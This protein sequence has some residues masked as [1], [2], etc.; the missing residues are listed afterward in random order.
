MVEHWSNRVGWLTGNTKMYSMQLKI[1]QSVD[2]PLCVGVCVTA[3]SV[4]VWRTVVC[5]PC[6]V[7][8]AWCSASEDSHC[9]SYWLKLNMQRN[10][11]HTLQ[12]VDTRNC[13]EIIPVWRYSY[14][15][16]QNEYTLLGNM[17]VDIQIKDADSLS[18]MCSQSRSAN[19]NHCYCTITVILI[20]FYPI[21]TNRMC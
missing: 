17:L 2:L 11:C 6:F 15:C 12:Y 8:R 16:L 19:S 13:W 14:G 21:L 10:C 7:V 3:V 18:D 9:I 5:L 20:T 4:T 1:W